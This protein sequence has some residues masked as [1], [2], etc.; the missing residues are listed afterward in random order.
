MSAEGRVSKKGKEPA[1]RPWPAETVEKWPLARISPY[2]NNARTHTTA[3]IGLIA[4]SIRRFGVTIPALV[5]EQGV[6]IAGHARVQAGN[7]AAQIFWHKSHGWGANAWKGGGGEASALD[8]DPV[9]VPTTFVILPDNGRDP[10]RTEWAE[11][12]WAEAE[13]LLARQAERKER[14]AR[15]YRAKRAKEKVGGP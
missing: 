9:S 14:E 15:R 7:V 5:D 3:D 6:L 1:R 2:A 8:E 11:S 4:E 12:V 13:A 10:D